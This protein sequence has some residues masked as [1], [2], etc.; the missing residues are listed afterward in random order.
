MY[1][2]YFKYRTKDLNKKFQQM[3]ET[4]QMINEKEGKLN[5]YPEIITHDIF[6][7]SDFLKKNFNVSFFTDIMDLNSTNISAIMEI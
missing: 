6:E 5:H 1:P 7:D 3:V 2:N 4:N